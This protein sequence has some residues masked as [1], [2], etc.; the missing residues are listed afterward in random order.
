MVLQGFSSA[1]LVGEQF[2]RCRRHW[3]GTLTRITGAHHHAEENKITTPRGTQSN[4]ARAPRTTRKVS[5]YVLTSPV[6]LSGLRQWHF[7]QLKPRR[8]PRPHAPEFQGNAEWS[9]CNRRTCKWV[10]MDACHCRQ[11][12]ATSTTGVLGRVGLSVSVDA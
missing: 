3:G 7:R 8:G 12:G 5:F 10:S 2:D 4:Q 9:A 11:Q 1:R 6:V